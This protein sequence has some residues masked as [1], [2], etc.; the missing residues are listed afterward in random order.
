MQS[1]ETINSVNA[2]SDHDDAHDKLPFYRIQPSRG[3]VALRLRELWEYRELLYFLTWRDIKVR[4][5]QT[6]LGVAWAI[7]QPLFTMLV[8]TFIRGLAKIPSDGIPYP[9]FCYAALVPW[10]FFANGLT[11]SSNSL[12]GSSNLLSK[13]YFPRLTIPLAT[14]LSGVVD[15]VLAFVLL[16]VMMLYYG[17]AITWQILWLPLFLLL[18]LITSLGIGLWLSALNVQYRDV[19]YVVPF[20]AQF[21]MLATPIAYPSSLLRE[22]WRTIYGLNP[23]AGVVEGFRWAL[24]GSKITVGPLLMV[25]AL[26]A[27]LIL[28]GGAFYFRRMEKTFADIV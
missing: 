26:M 27:V 1:S 18:A 20:I 21:W 17:V 6:A 13:V 23:M 19:K 12:I 16:L 28:V 14:V 4:Y 15:L 2:N 7:I 11:N 9:V 8:F 10:T 3:W 22:P 24:L 5:K 25:S